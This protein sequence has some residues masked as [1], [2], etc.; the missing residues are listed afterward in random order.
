[1]TKIHQIFIYQIKNYIQYPLKTYQNF[2][3]W[4]TYIPVANTVALVWTAQNLNAI[5]SAVWVT[6]KVLS[7]LFVDLPTQKGRFAAN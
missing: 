7:A 1:M 6:E 2:Q 5:Q 3:I 4:N